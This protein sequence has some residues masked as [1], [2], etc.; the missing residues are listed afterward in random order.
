[1]AASSTGRWGPSSAAYD[2]T[3]SVVNAEPWAYERRAA[4]V[5]IAAAISRR[6]WPTLTTIAPPAASRYSRPSASTM[7]EPWASTAAGGAF[8]MDRRQT[9][10]MRLGGSCALLGHGLDCRSARWLA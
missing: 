1:M 4:W 6:P 7:V 10:V 8:A 3:A 9:R 2:S 5:A